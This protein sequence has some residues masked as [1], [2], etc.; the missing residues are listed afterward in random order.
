MIGLITSR[1]PIRGAMA[2][3]MREHIAMKSSLRESGEK[4]NM[5]LVRK[6][7]IVIAE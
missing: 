4:Q 2:Q 5:R 3:Q 6:S 7:K 1:E